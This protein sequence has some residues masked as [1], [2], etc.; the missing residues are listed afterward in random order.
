M[1]TKT[2]TNPLLFADQLALE[3]V[4]PAR[5]EQ[6]LHD[7]RSLDALTWNVFATLERHRDRSWLAHRLELLGGEDLRAPVRITNWVGRTQEP[8]LTPTAAYLA[9]VK[10]RIQQAGADDAGLSE[11]LAEHSDP[12]E[13][14]VLIESPDVV[15]LVDTYLDHY[16]AGTGGRDRL[17]EI[18]D[19]GLEHARRVGKRLAV[20]AVY[21]SGTDVAAT[22]STHIRE[23]RDG[24]AQALPHR[25][26]KIDVTL[27]ELSWQQLLK[28]WETE[29]DYLELAGQPVK[30]FLAHTAALGLR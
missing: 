15:C 23:L 2:T 30:A 14:P 21:A 13:V 3:L 12:V 6:A 22:V 26:G 24:L 18:V 17:T 10:E 16:P 9:S 20:A 5:V 28:V 1:K 19:A 7:P 29:A 11:A 4:D 8:R 25:S 27:R